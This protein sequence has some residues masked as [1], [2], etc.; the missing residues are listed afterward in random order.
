[1]TVV[2]TGLNKVAI[3]KQFARSIANTVPQPLAQFNQ[4]TLHHIHRLNRLTA[5]ENKRTSWKCQ[6]ITVRVI[7]DQL[8][9]SCFRG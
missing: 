2:V 6:P 4:T 3:K 5:P 9:G 8:Q 7:G 1:M